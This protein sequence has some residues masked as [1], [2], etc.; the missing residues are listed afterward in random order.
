MDAFLFQ[1]AVQGDLRVVKEYCEGEV[2]ITTSKIGQADKR[3][4]K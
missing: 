2:T 3:L 1:D 4:R